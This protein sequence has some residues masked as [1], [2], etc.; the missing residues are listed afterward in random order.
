MKWQK[1]KKKY[2]SIELGKDSTVYGKRIEINE[3]EQK[4]VKIDTLVDEG[5]EAITL[6]K[7]RKKT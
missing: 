1:A 5:K 2:I 4:P 3:F 6:K 7:W